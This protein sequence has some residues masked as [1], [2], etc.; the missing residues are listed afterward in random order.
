MLPSAEELIFSEHI[1]FTANLG[2]LFYY[3]RI[4]VLG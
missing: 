2:T 3:I 4:T 1:I